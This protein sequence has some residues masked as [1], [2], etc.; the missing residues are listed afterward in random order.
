MTD[1]DVP[2]A[3]RRDAAQV[4][5]GAGGNRDRARTPMPWDATPGGGF[6]TPGVTPW[7]PTADHPAANVADQRADAGSTL[8]LCRRLLALRRTELSGVIADFEHLPASEG[9]WAYR[10]G[11][12]IVVANF[13]GQPA[14][15][16]G[17]AGEILLATYGHEP[18]PARTLAGGV[19]G[20]W[21]GLV[22]RLAASRRLRTHTY[23]HV[24][25]GPFGKFFG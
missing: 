11:S 18:D 8:W 22:A 7:L 5:G 24:M 12:L 3:L 17:A 23:S 20:P 13:S 2:A 9:Q 10:V 15:I 1:V 21:Q 6:T 25:P 16:P 19:L 4:A 14:G